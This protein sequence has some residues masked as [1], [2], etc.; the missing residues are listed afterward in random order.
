MTPTPAVIAGYRWSHLCLL[1]AFV[2]LAGCEEPSWHS[3]VNAVIDSDTSTGSGDHEGGNT[4]LSKTRGACPYVCLPQEQ[5]DLLGGTSIREARCQTPTEVCCQAWLRDSDTESYG[6]TNGLPLVS[7]LDISQIR[8]LQSVDIPLMLNQEVPSRSIPIIEHKEALLRIYVRPQ[9]DWNPREVQA[10]VDFRSGENRYS[11]LTEIKTIVAASATENLPSTFNIRIPSDYLSGN[12]EYR[13]SL[14][15]AGPASISG[16]SQFAQWPDRGMVR[17][18]EQSTS[19]GIRIVVI[20]VGYL[21]GDEFRFPETGAAQLAML[22]EYLYR[23]YPVAD[24]DIDIIVGDSICWDGIITPDGEG[25]DDLLDAVS[26]LRQERNANTKEY[27]Y[28]LVTPDDSFRSF[29][30]YGCV[31]GLGYVLSKPEGYEWGGRTAVGLG[32]EGIAGS[33]MIHELGHNHGRKHAPCNAP[34]P[35]PDFPYLGGGTGIWGYDLVRDELR[36]PEYRKDFMGY[37]PDQWV[38][39]Y[40]YTGIF[41]WIRETNA[42]TVRRTITGTWRSLRIRAD[43]EVVAGRSYEM[44]IPSGQETPVDLLDAD[45]GLVRTVTGYFTGYDDLPGGMV[46]FPAPDAGVAYA[47]VGGAPPVLL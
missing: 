8:L 22:R 29:C 46:L 23:F 14:F 41:D 31:S 39:D 30:W 37:C 34:N 16:T 12:L 43:G 3:S 26:D 28:G 33:V 40:T 1:W 45:A 47:R 5:C 35:D 2:G 18:N 36:N 7:G 17:M 11:P 44:G 38:S 21:M 25:W 6:S 9:R 42:L 4:L 19:G 27:Y 32:F 13:V 10:W 20:P 24:N 15:E